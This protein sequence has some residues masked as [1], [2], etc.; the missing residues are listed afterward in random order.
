MQSTIEKT[1]TMKAVRIHAFGGADMLAYED[2]AKPQP[3]ENEVL[4]RVKAAGVNP[5][6]W[7]IREGYLGPRSFP[8]ITGVDFSGVIE[9][10]GSGTSAFR[11]GDEVFGRAASGSYAEFAVAR[12]D[13]I[14]KKPANITHIHAAALPV[15]AVTAWQVLFDVGQ[16]QANQTV[17]IHAAAGGVG[18]FAVQFAKWKKAYVIGTASA[19][20]ADFVETLGADEVID[21][22]SV[23]FENETSNVDLVLDTIGGETQARSWGVLKRGGM[24]VSIVQPPP[25]ETAAAHGVRCVFWV[26]EAKS[27]ELA[28]IADLVEE[29][30]V[31]VY[32]EKTLP[33]SEARQAQELSQGGHTRGKMVLVVP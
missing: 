31:K 5:V 30:K 10:I 8:F 3:A 28:Q 4:V 27:D 33:L 17:L 24:L 9:G 18:G 14:A 1:R 15:A 32:V 11:V 2:V 26:S 20:N 29:G 7:K 6:D 12:V 19:E 16:L 22:R 13:Q 25:E 23:K 21:Y